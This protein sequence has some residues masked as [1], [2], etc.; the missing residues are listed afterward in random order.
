QR[1]PELLVAHA[2]EQR[3]GADVGDACVLQVSLQDEGH[4]IG[5]LR[6]TQPEHREMSSL[7]AGAAALS[8]ARLG[9]CGE[10]RGNALPMR[11]RGES[12]GPW[13]LARRAIGS[14]RTVRT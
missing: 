2:S 5:D 1:L 3:C 4:L 6:G 7:R 12:P 11:V 10:G 14:A 13:T 9:A 8:N